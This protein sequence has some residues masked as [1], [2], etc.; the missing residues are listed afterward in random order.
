[1]RLVTSREHSLF[2]KLCRL[3]QVSRQRYAEG[4]TLLDGVHLLQSCLAAGNIPELLIV[5]ESGYR[6]AEVSQLLDRMTEVY[7]KIGC[8]LLSDALFNQLSPVKTPVGVM[9]L[10]RIP[11]YIQPSDFRE[12]SFCI[13]L[14]TVQDPGNLGSILRSAA[15]AGVQNVF[16]SAG[17]VDGWSPKVLRAG[18]G[19]HFSLKI[20]E[21][22]DSIQIARRFNGNI[23]A[24][25]LAAADS[26]YRT[27]L[28]GSVMFIFG[29]EGGGISEELLQV[30]H[31]HVTIPMPGCAES[32]NVAAAA[33]ICLFE[34]V[35]QESF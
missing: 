25:A 4:K 1:M 18:M 13:L 2:K 26:I 3:Q 8:L 10:I 28:R 32:L 27:D 24:T 17:C 5:S 12:N 22:V 33:A 14:E 9:A 15:A 16:L 19:A 30:V 7:G 21:N 11:R 35:R 29:N 23:V 31:K 34:K 6:R 20:Y